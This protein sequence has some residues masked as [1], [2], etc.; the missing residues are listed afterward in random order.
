MKLLTLC[1]NGRLV[2][3]EY[4]SKET[5]PVERVSISHKYGATMY[6]WMSDSLNS[7]GFCRCVTRRPIEKYPFVATCSVVAS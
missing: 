1:K 3:F 4:I 2:V 6:V 7:E 5:D